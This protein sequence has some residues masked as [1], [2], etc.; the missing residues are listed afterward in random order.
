MPVIFLFCIPFAFCNQDKASNNKWVYQKST[1][2]DS[3][4]KLIKFPYTIKSVKWEVQTK[5]NEN[6]AIPGPSD[7]M[8]CAE[9]KCDST[10]LLSLKDSIS[11]NRFEVVDNVYLNSHF[12]K[13]WFSENTKAV[14]YKKG[15]LFRYQE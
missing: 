9:I 4:N 3:F 13:D 2:I 11:A 6:G 12:I 14:F 1:S 5:N 15:R 10:D 7:E 8:I